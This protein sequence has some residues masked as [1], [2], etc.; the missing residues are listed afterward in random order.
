MDAGF[1]LRMLQRAVEIVDSLIQ[2][3]LSQWK[4]QAIEKNEPI[5]KSMDPFEEMLSL[6]ADTIGLYTF[7]EPFEGTL[8]ESFKVILTMLGWRIWQNS[9]LPFWQY[10]PTVGNIRY[11]YH[12]HRLKS[13]ISQLISQRLTMTPSQR[14]TYQDVLSLM[15][16]EPEDDP[17]DAPQLAMDRIQLRD[18]C[19]GLVFAGHDT[20]AST[21]AWTFYIL[22]T[23]PTMQE[24]VRQELYDTLEESETPTLAQ[25]EKLKYM[26]A[27]IKEVLRMY[28]PAAIGR[29]SLLPT[30]VGSYSLPAGSEF[31]INIYAMHRSSR[32][33]SNP[34]QFDPERFLN[35]L[36][37]KESTSYLPFG[38]APRSCIGMRLALIEMKIIL[39][40][41]LT[42]CSLEPVPGA[43]EPAMLPS[44][45]FHPIHIRCAARFHDPQG[46]QD[47]LKN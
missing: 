27:V 5:V 14:E 15:I 7:S 22:A 1:T 44:L 8:S 9:L 29:T 36:S 10:L 39:W 17:G 45:T 18:E 19:V 12:L 24:R 21:L 42:S 37:E 26:G 16:T 35:P 34:H 2:T 40:R 41:T 11:W 13:R 28:P 31:F 47:K 20:T 6:T 25:L 4:E 23:H 43:R 30:T 32:Y 46:S 38:G 3:R 33:W